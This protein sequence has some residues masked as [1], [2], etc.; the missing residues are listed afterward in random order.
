MYHMH[1]SDEPSIAEILLLLPLRVHTGIGVVH[2]WH[3]DVPHIPR[4]DALTRP[5]LFHPAAELVDEHAWVVHV[6]G[7]AAFDS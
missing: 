5:T 3:V 1:P 4:L 7:S 6:D 2:E